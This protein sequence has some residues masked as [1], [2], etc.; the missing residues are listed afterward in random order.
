MTSQRTTSPSRTPLPDGEYQCFLVERRFDADR[1]TVVF[2]VEDEPHRGHCLQIDLTQASRAKKAAS[3][4]GSIPVVVHVVRR[5]SRAGRLY[6]SVTDF[7]QLHP[8]MEITVFGGMPAGDHGSEEISP[9]HYH[10]DTTPEIER[11]TLDLY[12]MPEGLP[13]QASAMLPEQLAWDVQSALITEPASGEADDAS[14][15]EAS[16]EIPADSWFVRTVQRVAA[17]YSLALL[18]TPGG[19]PRLVRYEPAF[20][21]YCRADGSLALDTPTGITAFQYCRDLAFHLQGVGSDEPAPGAYRGPA[22]AR[23]L[24][25]R[26]AGYDDPSEALRRCRLYV[27]A[28]ARLGVQPRSLMV[29]TD[30]PA[31]FEVLFPSVSFGALPRPGFEFV[32]A[33]LA[34]FISDWSAFCDESNEA[35]RNRGPCML[36]GNL[37]VDLGPYRRLESIRMPNTVVPGTSN[38]KVRVS[39]EELIELDSA[40]LESLSREPRAFEPPA[41]FVTPDHMLASLWTFCVAVAVCRSQTVSQLVD[42]DRW[43]HAATFDFVRRGAEPEELESRL[44]RAAMNLLDFRCP[45]PLLEAL[46]GPVACACNMPIAR[47]KRTIDH[48]IKNSLHARVLPVETF[49]GPRYGKRTAWRDEYEDA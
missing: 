12:F 2:Q 18:D 22:W 26:F 25:V 7:W 33:Y 16:P 31:A 9:L 21:A 44:F 39:A 27:T 49:P 45:Q 37:G 14:G 43:I 6:N 35:L 3:L 11:Q 40:E 4:D 20:A 13:P 24:P 47:F 23:W 1:V 30:G 19:P 48:A 34:L 28:L 41:W 15:A 8:R 42:G 38:F 5:Q 10:V 36:R 17:E 29:F 32:A 46:L